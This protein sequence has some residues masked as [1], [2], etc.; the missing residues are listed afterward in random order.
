MFQSS[1]PSQDPPL[2]PPKDEPENKTELELLFEAE[3]NLI[4]I[5]LCFFS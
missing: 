1:G 5:R 4:E 3:E 2:P